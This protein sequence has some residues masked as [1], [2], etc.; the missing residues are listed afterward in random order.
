LGDEDGSYM[1]TVTDADGRYL[2]EDLPWGTYDAVVDG[3]TLPA[4]LQEPPF[5]AVVDMDLSI[6]IDPQTPDILDKNFVYTSSLGRIGGTIYHENNADWAYNP[7]DGDF[8]IQ[9]VSVW[10]RDESGVDI[11]E[12]ATDPVGSYLF[13]ELPLNMTYTVLADSSTL[14]AGYETFPFIP[15]EVDNLGARQWHNIQ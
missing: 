9:G 2:F 11:A 15:P 5:Y 3:A 1:S 8:P 7:D 13:E 6:T 14:P 4:G 12:V 10:L